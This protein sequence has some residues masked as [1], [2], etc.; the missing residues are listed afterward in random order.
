[1]NECEPHDIE[2]ALLSQ[3]LSKSG[4]ERKSAEPGGET[5]PIRNLADT[6][7][8]LLI[9]ASCVKPGEAVRTPAAVEA[10]S[11]PKE[12]ASTIAAILESALTHEYD[13]P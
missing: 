13:L 5:D 1:M 3:R 2:I 7:K 11:V 12:R 10:Y 8:D 4:R 6:H 9:Q